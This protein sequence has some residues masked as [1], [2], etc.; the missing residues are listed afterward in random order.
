MRAAGV[1]RAATR[2]LFL[3]HTAL[4]TQG[5][6]HLWTGLE[7]EQRS[8]RRCRTGDPCLSGTALFGAQC[9]DVT[10]ELPAVKHILQ[11]RLSN[12][13]REQAETSDPLA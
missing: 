1:Q 12:S 2:G 13:C 7:V 11:S 10:F 6:I 4:E 9:I 5:I 8:G 3:S